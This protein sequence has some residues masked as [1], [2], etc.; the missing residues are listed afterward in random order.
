MSLSTTQQI[1]LDLTIPRIQNVRCVQDD[2]NTRLVRIVVTN[3]GEPFPLNPET[4]IISYKVCKPDSHYVW[5]KTGVT[6]NDDGTVTVDL[7]DQALAITGIAKSALRIQE[8]PD[9]ISTLP[10][11]IIVEKAVVGN[12]EL[13]SESESDI[14]D[15]ME[16]HL[17]DYNNPHKTDAEQVGLGNVPNVTT[18]DQ[19][20]TYAEAAELT[21]LTSGETLSAAFG[22][23]AK[24]VAEL[25]SHLS[26][27]F[28]H[29]TDEERTAWNSASQQKHT[30]S[31]QSVL[32]GISSASVSNW[33]D[34]YTKN[35]V[36]NKFST[37][38]TNIDWKES[39]NTYDDIAAAYPN[40]QDGW[41]VNVKDTD[42]TYRYNGLEWVAISANAIPKATADI[43]GLM[44]K[45]DKITLDNLSASSVTGVKGAAETDYRHGNINITPANI[46]LGNVPNVTTNDQTPTFTQASVRENLA[47]GEKMST[48]L[49]K[50]MKWFAD[51]KTVAFTGSYND[52]TNKPSIPATVAVKGN[53]E[54]AYRTG[55]VNIT[56][57]N[58]GLGNVNNTADANKSVNYAKSAGSVAW[59]DVTGK[60]ST[61][62]PSSHAHDYIPTSAS[63]N[64]NWV[65]SGQ[66]GQPAWLWGS[67]DGVNCYVW[68]PSNFITGQAYN[69]YSPTSPEIRN[70]LVKCCLYSNQFRP[71][72]DYTNTIVL[73]TPGARWKQ[74]YAANTT[75]STSD[76]NIK[77]DIASLTE[78]YENFFLLLQPVSFL[79]KNGDSGRTHIGFIS[80]DV[81]TAMEEAGLTDLDFAGFCKDVLIQ[82]VLDDDGNIKGETAVLDD[83]GNPVYIY[84][85]RYEEFIALNTHMVQR[86]WEKNAA[87]EE[88]INN[89][90]QA[91]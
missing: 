90:E 21:P 78:Q 62:P 67:N 65:Y 85:L 30:H 48:L 82:D 54:S 5:N 20:P 28:I 14:L 39:V 66:S 2:Q 41:T 76:R 23:L 86:L 74:I 29:I 13:I 44:S 72:T 33:N 70:D 43:D 87:L 81:E 9:K 35:E 49:G 58:I 1:T 60:P 80:Q 71:V 46:G 83:D 15:E 22:K 38:E 11:H 77:K 53:A 8:G 88:R 45:E 56:P 27:K 40:P 3:N 18:N 34:K 63:C 68:N 61:F 69:I 47:S 64:K 25:I 7:S 4:M 10:F 89:L 32:D 17:T 16:S 50:I 79:F 51:L 24:A 42:Y 75:I 59:G 37:L 57:A 19:T 31:N 12:D 91:E 26:N 6:I 36:D 52:L 84:S 55:N 73:G